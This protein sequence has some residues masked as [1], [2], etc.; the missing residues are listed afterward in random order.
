M[1]GGK[2]QQR[3]RDELNQADHA[4][5]K[6]AAGQLIDLPADR[7]GGDLLGKLRKTA[8]ADIEQERPVAE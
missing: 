7:D 5:I 2:H 6:G 4:E 1:P 8:G 3:R